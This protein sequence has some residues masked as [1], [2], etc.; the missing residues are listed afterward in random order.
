MEEI[1]YTSHLKS[2]L[3]FRAIAYNLPEKIYSQSNERYFDQHTQCFIAIGKSKHK[4]KSR[5]FA[6]TYQ[7]IPKYIILI[8]IHPLKLDQKTRRIKTGRWTLI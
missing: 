2:R 1:I 6:V 3:E 8:T 4:G 7:K 5:E